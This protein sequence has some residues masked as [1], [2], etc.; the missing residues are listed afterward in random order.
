MSMQE[1]K[2]KASVLVI[3]DDPGMADV[4]E[5]ILKD[6]GYEVLIAA[7]GYSGLQQADHRRVD[8]TITDL[9]LPDMSGLDVLCAIRDKDPQCP[10]IIITSYSTQGVSADAKR[11]GAIAVLPKPFDPS[12]ILDLVAKALAD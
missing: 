6:S 5:V 3:D 11:R 7:T 4:L 12:D 8:L 9:Q 2:R 1:M 10:V